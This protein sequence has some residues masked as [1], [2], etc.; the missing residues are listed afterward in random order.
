M[1]EVKLG[2]SAFVVD[3]KNRTCT[4]GAWDLSG[5][6]CCHVLS[7]IGLMRLHLEDYVDP[8]YF[9]PTVAKVYKVGI[10]CLVGQQAWPRAEGYPIYPPKQKK[11]PGRPKKKRRKEAGEL[12]KRLHRDGRPSGT[13]MSKKGV[14]LHCSNCGSAGH[15]VRKCPNPQ[16][17]GSNRGRG[18]G[19]QA[20][21]STR[22]R[23][24]GQQAEGSTRPKVCH[25]FMC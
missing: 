4:C 2:N 23:G 22:G 17:G 11:M 8:F 13:G 10:P 3:L 21:G 12:E 18:R 25:L 19:Q 6:P 1:V 20:G 15:N 9:V 5:L 14:L 7:A 24:I 16:T